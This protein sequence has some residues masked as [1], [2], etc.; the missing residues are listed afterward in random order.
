[1][2]K[3]KLNVVLEIDI[4]KLAKI[5]GSQYIDG[6]IKKMIEGVG[7]L[8]EIEAIRE[9]LRI[10]DWVRV[11]NPNLKNRVFYKSGIEKLV[12]EDE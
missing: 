3:V 8:E 12:N 4:E 7:E 11:R 6:G 10:P 1:M 2:S 9:P 5:T